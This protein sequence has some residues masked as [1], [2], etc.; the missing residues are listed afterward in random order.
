M[1]W[2]DVPVA[3]NS[4]QQLIARYQLRRARDQLDQHGKYLRLEIVFA[5]VAGKPAVGTIERVAAAAVNDLIQEVPP[6]RYH[7]LTD[8]S[9]HKSITSPS[10]AAATLKLRLPVH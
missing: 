1:S 6:I 3:P 4:V 5:S 8:E 9:H 10:A 7:G 2:R